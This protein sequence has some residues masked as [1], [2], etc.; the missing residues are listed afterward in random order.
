[1]SDTRNYRLIHPDSRTNEDEPSGGYVEVHVSH[2]SHET[3]L[4][5]ETAIVLAKLGYQVLR[6][7][8]KEI[9]NGTICREIQ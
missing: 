9:V 8:H 2:D 3:E 1:M 4:N 6:R 5:I 7:K